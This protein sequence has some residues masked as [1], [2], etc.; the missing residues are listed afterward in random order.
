[1]V[2]VIGFQVHLPIFGLKPLSGHKST[3]TKLTNCTTHSLGTI[4]VFCN[5]PF[6][7]VKL[8]YLFLSNQTRYIIHL[9]IGP[10]VHWSIGPLV[11]WLNV[12]C[13]IPYVKCHKSNVKCQ[14]PN[15]N[16]IKLLSEHNSGAPPV[17]SVLLLLFL[18]SCL[19]CQEEAFL[20][21]QV[22]DSRTSSAEST[23]TA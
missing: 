19:G 8:I 17:I 12:K 22:K 10:L 9:V 18:M 7:K 1:M 14:M 21:L 2:W 5:P 6:L 11:Y 16:K 23:K 4:V 13:Q 3:W 15:V 20:D